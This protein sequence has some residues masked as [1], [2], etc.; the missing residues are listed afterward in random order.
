M[1][2]EQAKLAIAAIK[3]HQAELVDISE[4]AR[5]TD[6]FVLAREHLQSWADRTEKMLAQLVSGDEAANF[7]KK[8]PRVIFSDHRRTW[9]MAVQGYLNPLTALSE[10]LEKYPEKHL[11]E[12]CEWPPPRSNQPA[13]RDRPA[14][15]KP[16]KVF[17]IHGHDEVNLLRL[18][19]LLRQDH[20][21]DVV[22]LSDLPETG[23]TIID[24]FEE[25]AADSD[26]AM[27]F[28][29][30]GDPADAAKAKNPQPRPSMVFELGWLCGRLGRD[31]TC[32]L[33]KKGTTV[34]PDLAGV[35]GV[36]FDTDVRQAQPEILRHLKA[37]KIPLVSIPPGAS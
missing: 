15:N 21:L 9:N 1:T 19:K 2:S 28:Y 14:G 31:R 30:P 37:A 26:F 6:N 16:A 4:R 3:K 10:S 29:E 11:Y 8:N 32:I 7:H 5:D 13:R 24:T 22:V 27:V 34:H 25:Q 18:E 35:S 36:E 33:Y 23:Q 12:P 17:I 20:H